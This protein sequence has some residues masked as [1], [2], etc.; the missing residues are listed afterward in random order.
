MSQTILLTDLVHPSTFK[1]SNYLLELTAILLLHYI[2]VIVE[3]ENRLTEISKTWA[4][5]PVIIA[6]FVV[7]FKMNLLTGP[8]ISKWVD[9]WLCVWS[10]CHNGIKTTKVWAYLLGS[11]V[12]G[13]RRVKRKRINQILINNT[14]IVRLCMQVIRIFLGG[15]YSD[16]DFN[17][18]FWWS[19]I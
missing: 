1:P 2:L 13:K 10:L 6:S 3:L 5:F 12:L 19:N 8:G 14:L 7:K 16:C 18:L 17:F 15:K 11:S 9:T 4:R